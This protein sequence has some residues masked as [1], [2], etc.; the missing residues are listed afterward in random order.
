[1]DES[2]NV[3]TRG[4]LDMLIGAALLVGALVALCFPVYLGSYDRYGM[5]IN[6]GNGY[7]SQLLQATLDD[8]E[9][10]QH[11]ATNYVDQC[12]SAVA[13]RRAWVLPVAGLAVLILI[14]ELV[15][16]ARG[17]S[18]M[19]AGPALALRADTDTSLQTAELLDRR[20]CSHRERAA[21]T[22][23]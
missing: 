6:C 9:Q 10:A 14:P 2:A 7:S 1:M 4:W 5:Q 3:L 22:T 18:S 11:A 19:P 15:A 17:E 13:H 20:E 16:W 23:L 8:Q 12:K 21:N